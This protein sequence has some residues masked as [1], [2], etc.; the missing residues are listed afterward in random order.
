MRS[1]LAGLTVAFALLAGC[2]SVPTA[3]VEEDSARKRFDPPPEQMAG[4]YIYRNSNFGAALKKSVTVNGRALG[5]TA[6]MTYFYT[7]VPP[8]EHTLATESEFG[9]NSLVL[10]AEAGKNYFVR[11]YIKMG[12]FV[13]GSKLEMVDE[14]T[15]KEG[16]LE[17]TL[18][19]S[20]YE[21]GIE[22]SG[23]LDPGE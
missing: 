6:P 15:G 17:C 3:T 22:E 18:A 2:A 8:G 19:A 5:Q 9:D 7:V 11:Q 20:P 21:P 12:V 13:G 23:S 14:A 1:T 10:D 4:I 16:V